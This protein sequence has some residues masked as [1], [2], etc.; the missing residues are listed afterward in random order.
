[1]PSL[2][3]YVMVES[4]SAFTDFIEHTFD[5]EI[6][7][8]VPL[9][10]DP[11]RVIHAQARIGDTTLYFADSGP[12][13]GQCRPTPAEPAHIHLWTVV[14]DPEAVYARAIARGA[15][16]AMEVTIQQDGR[17]MGGFVDR[18]GTLWW[19]TEAA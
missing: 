3:P 2:T 5:A 4:A 17:R 11:E 1:M 7:N 8:V 10:S 15:A 16:S 6:S 9:Q 13:G 14:P 12:T 19:V 18:F